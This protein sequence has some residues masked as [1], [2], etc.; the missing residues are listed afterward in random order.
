[1]P[2]RRST[3]ADRPYERPVSAPIVRYVPSRHPK[4]CPA[5]GGQTH[6]AEG[7]DDP[8]WEVDLGREVSIEDL[9]V[10]PTVEG[11]AARLAGAAPLP[12]KELTTGNP[13][14][15]APPQRRLWFTDQLAPD[16][17]PYNIA[18]ANRLTGPLDLA[19]LRADPHHDVLTA[20]PPGRPRPLS[21][22]R[23]FPIWSARL[24][25]CEDKRKDKLI[26]RLTAIQP[27]ASITADLLCWR[28][29]ER[30][31]MTNAGNDQRS[32]RSDWTGV[33]RNGVSR[34]R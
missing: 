32:G 13:P 26:N 27:D 7:T 12:G 3:V 29:C 18:L 14:T 11:L 30:D 5:E 33:A 9:F 16:D 34:G 22:G 1:M 28:M 19:A 31:W 6:T 10:A 17:A 24:P 21:R 4:A 15:L 8:W 23:R 25:V 2:N 20:V